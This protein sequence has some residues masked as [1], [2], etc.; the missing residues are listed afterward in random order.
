MNTYERWKRGLNWPVFLWILII[1]LAACAAPF[2][3]SW[4]GLA[5]A[6]ALYVV[7]AGLGISVGYHRYFTHRAFRTYRP[8]RWLLATVGGLAGEGP[9]LQWVANHR[10]HHAHSDHEGDPHRPADGSWWAHVLWLFPWASKEE[11]NRLH[12]RWARDLMGERFLRFQHQTYIFWHLLLA[13]L[14]FAV[15]SVLVDARTGISVVAWGMAVRLVA[16]LHA[17]WAINSASHL[18]GYRRYPTDD[19]SRNLWWLA[20]VTFGEGW[21]N[22]HHA[23]PAAANHGHR[24]WELDPSYWTIRLMGKLGLAWKI[25]RSGA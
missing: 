17:T 5:A 6:A 21:H 11:R 1:H 24:W 23:F 10:K 19:N 20:L 13:G 7:T 16:V 3:F 14:C 18:W 9:V 8:I 15:G 22:N 4:I 12:S 2:F 25:R